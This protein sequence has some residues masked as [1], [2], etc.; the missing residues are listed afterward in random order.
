[1]VVD[2]AALL[3]MKENI[4]TYWILVLALIALPALFA[5]CVSAGGT[6]LNPLE[7]FGGESISRDLLEQ[8]FF[9][10]L[11]AFTVGGALA[12]SGVAYQSVLRNPLAEPFILG[13][14]GGA[15][16]GAAIAIGT[17]LAAFSCAVIPLSSFCGALL[18]LTLVMILA[19]GAGD[20]YSTNVML[21]GVVAGSVCSSAL[22]F[23]ISVMD[24]ETL[25][26]V[27]WWMLGSLQPEN[28]ELLYLV[29]CLSVLG[30]ALLFVFGRDADMLSFGEETAFH[31]GISPKT[32]AL[33]ILGTASLLTASAVT[34]SGIIGFVG[35]V[36]PHTLRR[37]FGAGHRRLFPI[38]FLAGGMF[39]ML[40]DTFA[41]TAL[42]PREIPVGVITAALGGPFFI[43]LINR[44]GTVSR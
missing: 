26:S 43:W 13:I 24:V 39:L 37:F 12:V 22:M 19:K 42:Y 2:G 40:C 10:V 35:L 36:V 8:R 38:S 11:T 29:L 33:I 3:F 31:F 23:M 16:V 41:R 25:H 30:T 1:M 28:S 27:T 9:R 14:S 20:E 5:L 7:L 21:S 34:L 15:S 44:K 32:S 6:L 18:V 17:G 4:K